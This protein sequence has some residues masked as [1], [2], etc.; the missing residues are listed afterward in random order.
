M[1]TKLA[2]GSYQVDMT[3]LSSGVYLLVIDTPESQ[4]SKKIIKE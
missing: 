2:E 4:L 1:E 3:N